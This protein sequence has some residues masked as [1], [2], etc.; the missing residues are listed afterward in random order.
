LQTTVSFPCSASLNLF[1]TKNPDKKQT[2]FRE[3]QVRALGW[4]LH[5][6]S[7]KEWAP[8][9]ENRDVQDDFVAHLLTQ[10]NVRGYSES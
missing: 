5:A 10:L 6:T 7:F 9:S 3:R 2:A 8:I 4:T 1:F